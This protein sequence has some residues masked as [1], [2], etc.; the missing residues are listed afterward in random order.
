ML[1]Q[2]MRVGGVHVGS[3]I[4]GQRKGGVLDSMSGQ[5]MKVNDIHVGSVTTR[6][7]K[8]GV[9]DSIWG[10]YMKVCD[11]HVHRDGDFDG[12]KQFINEVMKQT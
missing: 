10:Q 7:H 12:D 4:A 8:G 3:V 11:V 9:L 2:C 6:Q 1:G 5:C